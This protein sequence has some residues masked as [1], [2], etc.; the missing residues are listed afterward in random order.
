MV[1]PETIKSKPE[2]DNADKDS[3]EQ[4]RTIQV[5]RLRLRLRHAGWRHGSPG[6]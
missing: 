5:V 4:G 3:T 1:F 2:K 6:H